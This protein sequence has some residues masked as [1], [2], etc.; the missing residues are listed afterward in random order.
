M[1]VHV[2]QQNSSEF[3]TNRQGTTTEVIDQDED[4][5]LDVL[6]EDASDNNNVGDDGNVGM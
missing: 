5:T 6:I 2:M 3:L 1:Q 4:W